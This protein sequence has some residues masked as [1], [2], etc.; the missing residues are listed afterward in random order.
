MNVPPYDVLI[1]GSGLAGLF[2]ALKQPRDLK[3]ALITKRKLA[4][5]ETVF[6]QG[7][8]SCV[9]SENDS[10]SLHTKDTLK[11]GG[12]LSKK[13]IV[14]IVVRETPSRLKE[15]EE[16]G[17]RFNKTPNGYDLHLEGGHS[18][19]RIVHADD[20]TGKTIEDALVARVKRRKNESHSC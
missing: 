1:I 11:T 16:Y 20:H 19:R 8:I 4:D 13:N 12:G 6:A 3:V 5:S 7:G 18:R 10:F 17:V 9:T 15:L 2:A 14:D